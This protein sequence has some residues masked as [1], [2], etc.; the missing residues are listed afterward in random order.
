MPGE[1][2]ADEIDTGSCGWDCGGRVKGMLAD[3]EMKISEEERAAVSVGVA[4]EVLSCPEEEEER[5]PGRV[6][7]FSSDFRSP[8]TG[9]VKG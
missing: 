9:G 3:K 6:D 2:E 1:K 8:S 4:P 5:N 7:D